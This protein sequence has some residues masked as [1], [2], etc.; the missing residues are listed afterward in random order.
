[1]T[2]TAD[3]DFMCAAY[4]EVHTLDNALT[5]NWYPQRVAKAATGSSMLELGV[6][7][8]GATAAFASRF[9][10]YC[11]VEGSPEIA[12]RFRDRFGDRGI[13]VVISYFEDFETDERFD[14]IGMGFVLEHV[15]DPAAIIR[16]YRKFMKPGGSLFAAVPNCEALHR[17]IGHAAGLLPDLT[18]LS[19]N[20]IRVGHKRYFSL[21]TFKELFEAEGFEVLGTEG[22]ML[23]P[24]T[25]DQ[26][27]RLDLSPEVLQGLMQ[28]GIDYPELCNSILLHARPIQAP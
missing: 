11:V 5:Q 22:L 21:K 23:K 12:K 9:E 26:L 18:K 16:R 10:R 20:D 24:L 1:M 27:N 17:R 13:E 4:D 6:G 3:L 25:T 8:G 28:V 2:T 19:G 15:D 7:H 14:H